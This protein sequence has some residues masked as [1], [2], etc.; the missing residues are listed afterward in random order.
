MEADS[1]A[2]AKQFTFR[3]HVYEYGFVEERPPPKTRDNEFVRLAVT[4]AK[5]IK[6]AFL[7]HKMTPL[8]ALF[9]GFDWQ[10]YITGEMAHGINMNN[11]ILVI[12]MCK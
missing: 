2:R 8:V 7:G 9:P 4:F 12:H 11:F 3:G 1:L 10:R 5:H 6:A